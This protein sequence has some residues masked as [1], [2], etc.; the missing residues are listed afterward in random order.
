VDWWNPRKL[1]RITW[2][3]LS[4]PVNRFPRTAPHKSGVQMKSKSF[5]NIQVEGHSTG[6]DARGAH[7]GAVSLLAGMP[8]SENSLTPILGR[9]RPTSETKQTKPKK[10]EILNA[11]AMLRRGAQLL[12]HIAKPQAQALSSAPRSALHL[13]LRHG[14]RSRH[15]GS[16]KWRSHGF[17]STTGSS[18]RK[19]SSTQYLSPVPRSR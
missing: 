8:S 10:S 11:A 19:V 7:L 3:Q 9:Q 2:H 18:T 1:H 4:V 5:T 14:S 15:S 13:W 12:P 6:L 16:E 17:N